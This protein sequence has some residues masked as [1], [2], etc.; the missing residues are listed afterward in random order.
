NIHTYRAT[1]ASRLNSCMWTAFGCRLFNHSMRIRII[2]ENV[3]APQGDPKRKE[4]DKVQTICEIH[5][6]MASLHAIAER[7]GVIGSQDV[8]NRHHIN[9]SNTNHQVS[10]KHYHQLDTQGFKVNYV[11]PWERQDQI[12]RTSDCQPG[13]DNSYQRMPS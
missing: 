2:G 3:D 10:W 9:D 13:E 7:G 12:Q 5:E 11:R 4:R 8:V 1:G 6:L